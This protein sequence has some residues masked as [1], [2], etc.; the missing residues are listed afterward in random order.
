MGYMNRV[1]R[2]VFPYDPTVDDDKYL[3]DTLGD[4]DSEVKSTLKTFY[5]NNI[6]TAQKSFPLR[7]SSVNVTKSAV[8]CGFDHI[9]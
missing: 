4:T 6:D 7:I 5:K 3:S 8:T 1:D 2:D 9:Y